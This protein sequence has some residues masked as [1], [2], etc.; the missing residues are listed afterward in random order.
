MR[1]IFRYRRLLII[2]LELAFIIVTYALSSMLVSFRLQAPDVLIETIPI[3]VS[4]KLILFYRF[5]LF[6]GW[7]R[8]V[9][10]SDALNITLASVS[11]SILPMLG[12]HVSA[13]PE[14]AYV[15]SERVP[16][17]RLDSVVDNS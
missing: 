5:G 16:L 11:S 13:A 15:S 4:V 3:V 14:S 10:M 6:S 9:G 7:W 12:A 17:R 1:D 8:Y 2:F